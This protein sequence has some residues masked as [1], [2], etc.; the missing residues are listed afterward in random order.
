L[1]EGE[2]TQTAETEACDHM[3][4]RLAWLHSNYYKLKYPG[5]RDTSFSGQ[6]MEA[7]KLI[8]S[9]DALEEFQEMSKS[10]WKKLQEKFAAT[11][12]EE[13]HKV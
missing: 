1:A 10:M 9:S 3:Y 2:N 12:P 8:L 13:K 6:S 4:K 7:Y 5:S 11:R